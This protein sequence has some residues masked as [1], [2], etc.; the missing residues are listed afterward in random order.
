MNSARPRRLGPLPMRLLLAG[1][2]VAQL[3]LPAVA[4]LAR[5]DDSASPRAQVQADFG[6]ATPLDARTA[7]VSLGRVEYRLATQA[8]VG[9]RARVFYVVPPHIPGLRTPAGLTVEWRGGSLFAPGQAQPGQR[10]PVWTGV[11]RGPW[12]HD[13]QDLSFVLDMRALYL[14]GRMPLSFESYFEIEVL[15]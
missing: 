10:V 15:P 2:A 9:Q 8:Y 12:L 11:V 6:R 4:Q 1:I 14:P 7:R 3:A 13:S 5:L